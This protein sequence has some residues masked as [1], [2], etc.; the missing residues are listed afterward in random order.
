LAIVVGLMGTIGLA[1]FMEY[2][3]DTITNPDEITNRFQIP[4]LGVAPLTKDDRF[5]VELTFATDPRSPL[6]EAMRSTKV[7]LQ[8]SGTA[9]QSRSFLLTSS[10]P[11]EGKTTMAVNL[12]LAFAGSG[13]KVVLVDADMRKP[14]L[15]EFFQ[16]Q[17]DIP[18]PGLSSFLAGVGSNKSLVCQ[19][20]QANLYFIPAGPIPPNPVE[21]L[22]SDRFAGLMK[23]LTQSFDCVILDGPPYQGFAD[24]LVLSR[25]VGGVVL[26]SSIGETTRSS[27]RHFKRSV[28][29]MQGKVLGCII[30]KV[31]LTKRY[32]YHPYYKYYGYFS[33]DNALEHKK[34]SKQLPKN[35]A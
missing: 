5:P 33:Y 26:V 14:R 2:F 23:T 24:A 1:F 34:K 35:T 9:S 21:L 27:L 12:A 11:K 20:G 31:D 3:S 30:N 4:I 10:R 22:A 29:N 6:A 19:D 25:Y 13:E 32:G 17:S 28:L 16:P 18:S 7:S 8:L 15:Q